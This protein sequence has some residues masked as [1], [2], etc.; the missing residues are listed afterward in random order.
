M[1]SLVTAAQQAAASNKTSTSSGGSLKRKT[2]TA[3]LKSET[4]KDQK[5]VDVDPPVLTLDTEVADFAVQHV[6]PISP[7]DVR[8][9]IA[10]RVTP[11]VGLVGGVPSVSKEA[12]VVR[13]P[14]PEDALDD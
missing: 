11:G 6:S 12:S 10:R 9:P 5:D 8:K 14:A 7:R 4:D 13:R 2:K 1:E 3:D